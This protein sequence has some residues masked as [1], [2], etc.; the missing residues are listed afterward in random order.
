MNDIAVAVA[1]LRAEGFAGRVAVLDLDAHPPDGMAA[2]L[3]PTRTSGLARSPA[4]TGAR[5]PGWTRRCCPRGR[6]TRYLDALEALLGAHAPPAAGLRARRRR[7]PGGRPHGRLGLT[8]SRRAAAQ[9][10]G[11]HGAGGRALAS[12]CRAAATAARLAA[13]WPG[14]GIALAAGSHEPIP[15]DYD[16]LSASAS[17]GSRAELLPRASWPTPGSSPRR[18][19]RRRWGCAPRGSGSCSASTPRAAWSTPAPAL[20]DPRAAGAARVPAT[21]ASSSTPP[22]PGRAAARLRRGA[23][24]RSTC[25]SS[26]SWRRGASR[27]AGCSTSTGCRS[28]T[29]APSSASAA[30]AARPGGP[31]P[32][33]GPRGRRDAGAHG[34]APRALPA[35]SIRPAHYHMA[36]AGRH[37]FAF[38]DAARQGRFEALV[39]DLGP[40]PL[41]RDHHRR[42]RGAS[43]DERRALRL[44]GGR[45]GAL[46]PRA[47]RPGIRS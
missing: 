8:L 5:S 46:A 19:S 2:C 15:A 40:V 35:W 24:R 28:A 9:P 30:P 25:W 16:P 1:A 32:G 37:D 11:G 14:T 45:D 43:P 31:R 22:A 20:R 36:Y 18:T 38:V 47:P 33:A 12:G 17:P 4:R 21:S 10:G 34:A 3:A 39:R 41:A 42:G 29:R 13:R 26:S 23:R 27:G 7:R 44:G 6:A